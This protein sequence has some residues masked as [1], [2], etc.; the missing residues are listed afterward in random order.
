[1]TSKLLKNSWLLTASVLLASIFLT[2]LTAHAQQTA[3][4]TGPHL[5]KQ[6]SAT[7]LIVNGAPFLM[8]GGELGNSSASDLAYMK[9]VWP[10]LQQ[11]H[12]NTVLAPI[13]WEL[14]E[15]QEGKFDFTLVDGL[16]QQARTHQIKLVFLWFGSWKNS[17]SCYVPDWVKT[18][19]SR[20]PRVQNKAG[21]GQEILS[22]FNANNLEADSRAFTALMRHIRQTDERQQTVIMIQVENEIGMLPDARDHSPVANAAFAQDVPNSLMQYLQTHKNTLAPALLASWKSNGFK[23]SGSWETVF[24]KS[25]ATD[26]VFIAWHFA[27]FTDRVTAAGKAVYPLPMFVNAALNRPNVKPGDY[28]SG[29][30]LPH[31]I[32]V[33]KAGAPAIDFLSPDFYNPDF[34]Y[35]NDLYT[36][37]DNPLFIPEIRFEPSVAA[38]VFFAL[39]RYEAMGFSPFSIESTEHP[40][41]E[42]IAKSYDVLAQVSPLILAHQ[43][44]QAMAGF[45]FDKKTMTDTVR[46][47]GYTFTVKHDYSLGWSP[48]AKDD[49]WPQ[50]GGLII[51]TGADEF[52]VA[53]TGIVMTFTSDKPDAPVAGILRIDEGTYLNGKWVPGR[54]LNGDQ[55]HQG[56]HLRIPVGEYGSQKLTL[57]RYN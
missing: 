45:L 11:M 42:P 12:V 5:R 54:R 38:K 41:D 44:K 33:W 9:P 50:T 24:G 51:Q 26:E 21:R 47:G 7:Q 43:G 28:P 27:Q 13:Y 53:G 46:L 36:R 15:P 22:P 23:T 52:T 4:T 6:G 40:A 20:F 2:Q 8:L 35:W 56:R 18:N 49:E 34:K 14:L 16:I 17:M 1:M 31:V 19:T 29:G 55:D 10:K 32:D 57:Y 48:K 37:P 39:G 3:N 30:P 25:L